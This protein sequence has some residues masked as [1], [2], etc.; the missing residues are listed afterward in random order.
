[1]LRF[2]LCHAFRDQL[3]EALQ[4]VRLELDDVPGLRRFQ[5]AERH[6]V[7]RAAEVAA[8]RLDPPLAA[9]LGIDLEHGRAGVP[10]VADQPRLLE[11]A[12]LEETQDAPRERGRRRPAEVVPE[13]AV[14]GL[15]D[16]RSAQMRAEAGLGVGLVG[17]E[18]RV[19]RW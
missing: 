5:E 13:R 14:A 9:G 18:D 19:P 8:V 15:A 11:L 12:R 2:G 3:A 10:Q 4:P 17:G 1:M 16:L 7:E 6:R